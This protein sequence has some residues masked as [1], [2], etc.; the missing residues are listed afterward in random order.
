ML[1]VQMESKVRHLHAVM[2]AVATDSSFETRP[3]SMNT[4]LEKWRYLRD[5]TGEY[6]K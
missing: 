1:D 4:V 3:A 5:I 6:N 2:G